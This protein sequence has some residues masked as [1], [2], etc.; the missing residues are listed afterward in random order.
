MT[1]ISV[2]ALSVLQIIALI[3][4]IPSK[5]E[6]NRIPYSKTFSK[7]AFYPRAWLTL[8]IAMVC[9]RGNIIPVFIALFALVANFHFFLG[10]EPEGRARCK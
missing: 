8:D 3:M 7:V 2:K 10:L 9:F 4:N 1:L 5:D 6:K